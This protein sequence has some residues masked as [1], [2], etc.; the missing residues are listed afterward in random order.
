MVII[1]GKIVKGYG[2]ARQ[3]LE[4]QMP[5]FIKTFPEIKD[6]Y[7]GSINLELLRPLKILTPDFTTDP[8]KWHPGYPNLEERFGF[9]RIKLE[10]VN[11][12][13]NSSIVAAWIYDPH[14]SPHRPDPF[15]VEI[16]APEISLDDIKLCKIHLDKDYKTTPFIIV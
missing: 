11:S 5:Y 9:T 12:A 8:I 13:D 7:L 15:Y 6:C 2:A 4:W 3:N 1:E 10:T 16:I 14:N